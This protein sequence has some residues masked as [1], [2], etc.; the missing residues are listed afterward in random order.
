MKSVSPDCLG[1]HN[2]IANIEP[3]IKYHPVHSTQVGGPLQLH[4]HDYIRVHWKDVMNIGGGNPL[5]PIFQ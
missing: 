5:A 3:L 4:Y 1:I 2:I